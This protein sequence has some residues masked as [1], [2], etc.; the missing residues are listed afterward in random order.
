ML[1]IEV[2]GVRDCLSFKF[3]QAY[4]YWFCPIVAV[5]VF[6]LVDQE[7]VIWAARNVYETSISCMSFPTSFKNKQLDF[8][9]TMASKF[10]EITVMLVD[11][12]V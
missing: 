1:L 12:A 11:V 3:S 8:F 4:Y 7:N 9:K 5:T 10:S 2:V 6:G